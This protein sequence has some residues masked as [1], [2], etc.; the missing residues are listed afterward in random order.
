MELLCVLAALAV[1]FLFCA[2]LTLRC[3]LHSALAPLTALAIAV[4]WLTAA[5]MADVLFPGMVVLWI[6][7]AGLGVWAL[8]PAGGRRPDVRRL[9]TPGSVLFWAM[10]V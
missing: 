5:G 3:G 10:S 9:L 6:V 2:F 8:A 4:A 7:F 1:L